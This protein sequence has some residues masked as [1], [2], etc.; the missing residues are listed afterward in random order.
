MEGRE[1]G[2]ERKREEEREGEKRRERGEGNTSERGVVI[3]LDYSYILSF[4][5]T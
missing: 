2:K 4:I 1:G 3:L 5:S